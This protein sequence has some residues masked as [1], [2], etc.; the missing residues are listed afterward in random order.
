MSYLV[1]EVSSFCTQHSQ[2]SSRLKQSSRFKHKCPRDIRLHDD[3][4]HTVTR[5]LVCEEPRCGETFFWPS[6]FQKHYR[7]AH[8]GPLK[9]TCVECEASYTLERQLIQHQERATHPFLMGITLTSSSV[10]SALGLNI[11]N[12]ATPC[13]TS[14]T[15]VHASIGVN[16]DDESAEPGIGETVSPSKL[17]V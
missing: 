6:S 8:S 3:C 9:Y 7:R 2:T 16:I 1:L 12:T 4:I 11:I 10:V 17:H 13:P 15:V 5:N 14:A